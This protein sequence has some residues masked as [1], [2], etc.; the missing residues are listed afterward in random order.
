MLGGRCG[1][2]VCAVLSILV[3]TAVQA[4]PTISERTETFF[5]HVP[6]ARED[7]AE[8]CLPIPIISQ[9]SE[10]S[11][12]RF[13]NIAAEFLNPPTSFISAPALPANA[14]S[15]PGVPGALFMALVGFLCVSLVKDRKLWMAALAGLLW[16]GQAGFAVLPQL[17]L[18]IASKKQ[19]EQQVSPN[20]THSVL[21][22]LDRLRSEIEGTQF[23]GL[24]HYLEG[25]PA[26]KL[27]LPSLRAWRSNLKN[28]RNTQYDIRN[29]NKSPQFALL[30][31]HAYILQI[32][33]CAS[34]S[35][36]RFAYFSPAFIF[37]NLAR[38]PPNP[39]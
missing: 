33:K 15:L 24:L 21:E 4:A 22:H 30:A 26:S 19:I 29:T 2:G 37:V 1:K 35:S 16:M 34:A 27:V 3:V 18:Q 10:L 8:D 31:L 20:L 12:S 14:S 25:I 32:A 5:F 39:A 38:G 6:S 13:S 23:I 11:N 7:S 36:K 28:Q 17:A 9:L